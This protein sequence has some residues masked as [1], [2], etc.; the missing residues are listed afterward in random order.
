M[1]TY[2]LERGVPVPGLLAGL[3]PLCLRRPR[4]PTTAIP[5]QPDSLRVE[6][7]THNGPI[8]IG[9]MGDRK[10]RVVVVG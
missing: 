5:S 1:Y 10:S 4:V 2:R 6:P 3:E 8:L 9:E 7:T